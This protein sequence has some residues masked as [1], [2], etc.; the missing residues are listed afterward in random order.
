MGI[1]FRD[2]LLIRISRGA[3][4]CVRVFEKNM[5]FIII[6]PPIVNSYY[7]MKGY[8][9]VI[10]LNKISKG[11]MQINL[12]SLLWPYLLRVPIFLAM[13][14]Y[15][16]FYLCQQLSSLC[17]IFILLRNA[18]TSTPSLLYKCSLNVT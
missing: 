13:T 3:N 12:H 6:F 17:L 18:E 10:F 16:Y 14:V 5:Y 1:Y 11:L 2:T 4:N 8:I 9:C 7:P 15:L